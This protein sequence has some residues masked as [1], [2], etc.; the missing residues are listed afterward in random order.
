MPMFNDVK[1][2]AQELLQENATT[3]LTVGGVV[4]TVT[5]AVLTGR[6]TFQAAERILLEEADRIAEVRPHTPPGETVTIEPLTTKDKVKLIW[7]LYIPPVAAGVITVSS[8]IMANRMSAQ[9]VA[10]LAAAYGLSEKQF[11]EYKDKVTEK[12][13]GPKAT[14]I[15]DELAQDRV[16]NT[17]GGGTIVIMDGE[18]LCFDEPTGRYFRSTMDAINKAVNRTN[19][20]ILHHNYASASFFY[21]ELGLKP[22]TW[23][24]DVGWNVNNLV[25]LKISTVLAPE[26]QRPCLSIDFRYL[27]SADYIRGY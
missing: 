11:R 10:A 24:D 13:T 15:D 7:L 26:N 9:K 23:S 4:G 19:E 22:T 20:E 3:I 6:S 1:Q 8:I 14:A 2:R 27:P 5:T 18:V 16:N 12:V 25:D 21:E 17:P